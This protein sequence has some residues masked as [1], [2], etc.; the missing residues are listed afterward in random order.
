MRVTVGSD[1]PVKIASVKRAFDR[2]FPGE[3]IEYIGQ[4]TES[5]VSDQPTSIQET[6][7]GA[8]N[9]ARNAD[10]KDA[11]FSVGIEGG[12]SY[13]VIEGRKFAVEMGWACVRDNKTGR[14][15]LANSAGFSVFERVMKHIHAGK[16]LSNAMFDEYG[17]EN[18]GQKNGYIGWLSNDLT[19]RETS[20]FEAVY[21]A[22]CSLMKEESL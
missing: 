9:R 18:L 16:N 7:E 3:N 11:D 1:N 12:I 21:L 8:C 14:I 19:T 5:G 2:Y 20:N 10:Q 6:I 4:K 17:L 15:E 13:Y 22:L